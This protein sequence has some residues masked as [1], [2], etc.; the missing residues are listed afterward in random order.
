MTKIHQIAQLVERADGG[1]EEE[2]RNKNLGRKEGS[3]AEVN[4]DVKGKR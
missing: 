2:A 3:L 4:E 1:K